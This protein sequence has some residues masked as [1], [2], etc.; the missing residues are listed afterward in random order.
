MAFDSLDKIARANPEYVD[1]LYQQ[2]QQDPSSIDPQWAAVFAGY[3]FGLQAP[4]RTTENARATLPG[5]FDLVHSYRELGHLVAHVNPLED[6]PPSHPL[7]D[8]KAFGFTDRDMDKTVNAGSFRGMDRVPL[9]VLLRALK[10]TYCR[11]LGIEFMHLFDKERRDWLLNRMEPTHNHPP[12]NPQAR[13][14]ILK[15]LIVADGFERFLHSKYP[16]SKRFSLEGNLS[17]IPLLN[18]LV[19]QSVSSGAKEFV[20]GMPHRGR[21]NVL[22]HLMHKPY[23]LILA[24]FEG[25]QEEEDVKYHLGYSHDLVLSSGKTIH[26][27]LSANPSHLEAVNPVVLGMVRAKQARR[28]GV[29]QVVPVLMH[30]DAAFTGQGIVYETL[31]LSGLKGFATGGTVH[32][33][34]NNQIGFTTP[35]EQARSTPYASSLAKILQAPIFHVNADDPEAVVWAAQLAIGFRQAFQTDVL[36]DLIGYRR[37]GHNEQDDPSFTQPLMVAKIKDHPR[38]PQLYETRLVQTGAITPEDAAQMRQHVRQELEHCLSLARKHKKQSATAS[39]FTGMWEGLGP[40]GRDWHANTRVSKKRLKMIAQRLCELPPGFTPHPRIPKLFEQL[41][42]PVREGRNLSWAAGE[43]L[44]YGSLLLEG[45]PVRLTGQDSAR[46]TFSHRHAVLFDAK[47]GK[48]YVPLNHLSPQQAQ[49]EVINSPLSEAGVLGFEYGIS[50]AD[51]QRLVLWE[52]QFGD[53]AN[54]AQV[55]IDQFIASGEAKWA[56]QSGLV[57]LLP[58]GYEGQGPEHSSARLERFL[59]LCA[60]ENMQVVNCTTPAQFFHVLRR[61]VHRKFRKPLVVMTPKSLLRHKRAVSDLKEFSD[62]DFQTVLPDPQQQAAKQVRRV[63]LC[64]G[65]IYYALEAQRESL[66]LKET[67]AIHRVEQLYPFPATELNA[68]LRTYNKGTEFVWVQEEPQ[69]Q[70]AW[71]FI[72]PRLSPLVKSPLRYVGRCASASTATGSLKAHQ[73]EE[74][75]LLAEAFDL[76][77]EVL[78]KR[79]VVQTT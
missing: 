12:L 64:A 23:E 32:I 24:E 11:T 9:K 78:K 63:L 73:A 8:I 71:F 18:T 59:Q 45:I 57:L 1:R 77:I 54:G 49:I 25:L 38:E 72:E 65:K 69:N 47:T 36:I 22:T 62:A 13:R 6:Q 35:P 7:L 33:L 15:Q 68:V 53:F 28:G 60:E 29:Q 41:T 4:P 14:L 27:S 20:F 51:P 55:F 67:V 56:R 46:G 75:A 66:N 37:H 34:I 10:Q 61:Q 40:S 74:A 31:E 3:E 42:A 2:Y 39:A 16:G 19:E 21:L 5:V 76:N 48:P 70:G 43:L 50:S 52:A 58:H 30:G 26:L 44:A 17:L 79:Q